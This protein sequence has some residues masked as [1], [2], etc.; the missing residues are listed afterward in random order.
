MF[1]QLIYTSKCRISGGADQLPF[2]VKAIADVG[3]RRNALTGV[4]GAMML[5]NGIFA[6]VLEG[7]GEAP[8]HV[9]ERIARDS[10]HSD[11]AVVANR[12]VETRIFPEWSMVL[13]G[14]EGANPLRITSAG[15]AA[16]LDL[17]SMSGEDILS[18]LQRLARATNLV[19]T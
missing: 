6:Q 19:P 15:W 2:A 1:T 13:V 9:F 4:T 18:L 12:A 11:V 5:H 17:A 16:G 7:P 8:E 10:R 14:A 3:R